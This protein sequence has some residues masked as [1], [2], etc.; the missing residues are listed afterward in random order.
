MIGGERDGLRMKVAAGEHITGLDK[1]QWIVGDAIRLAQQRRRFVAQDVEARAHHLRLAT[2]AVGILDLVV[3]LPVRVADRAAFKQR[4]IHRRDIDLSRLSAKRM[5]PRIKRNVASHRRVDA[6][7]AGDDCGR[8]QFLGA[9][10]VAQ[11]E[12][13]RHL[14]AVD[15]REAFLRRERDRCQTRARQTIDCRQRVSRMTIRRGRSDLTQSEQRRRQMRERRKITRRANGSL[16]RNA[17]TH[18][19]V[20]KRNQCIDQQRTHARISLRQA[21]DLERENQPDD[22][23]GQR[24]TDPRAVRQYE[25]ALQR[26]ELIRWNMRLRE[27]PE[28][29]VDS[30]GGL[31]AGDDSIDG[32]GS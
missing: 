30:V 28:S 14:C 9:E 32:L 1:D 17:R 31:A 19:G 29:G 5:D 25:I 18:A 13:C 22:I 15:Q 21:A 27:L 2:Q 23:V 6:H 3:A 16:R 10:Q 4:S 26:L 24:R 11:R 7:R 20:E 12:R 8:E